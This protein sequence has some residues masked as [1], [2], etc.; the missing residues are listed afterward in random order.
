[1]YYRVNVTVCREECISRRHSGEDIPG[2]GPWVR[3]LRQGKCLELIWLPAEN[4]VWGETSEA[5]IRALLRVYFGQVTHSVWPAVPCLGV[6]WWQHFRGLWWQKWNNNVC[7]HPTLSLEGRYCRL[8]KS[9]FSL[10][11]LN[12]LEKEEKEL[13]DCDEI[14]PLLL[15]LS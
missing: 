12:K 1:M 7:R 15:Y 13:A 5:Q 6:K 10:S 4:R 11:V 2:A 8:C 3:P 9:L 14:W